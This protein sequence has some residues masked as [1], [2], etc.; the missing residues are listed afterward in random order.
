MKPRYT[1]PD[2]NQNE[3]VAEL[4]KIPALSVIDLREVGNDC[5]DI[6]IGYHGDNFLIEIKTAKGKVKPGQQRHYDEW[7]GQTAIARS[8]D[9]VLMIIGIEHE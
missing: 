6:L 4:L 1:P 7:P 5:P 3:I 9:D 8:L 2:A